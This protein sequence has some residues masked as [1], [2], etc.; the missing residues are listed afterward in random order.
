MYKILFAI[1]I[2][3]TSLNVF[4]QNK[5][6]EGL[7]EYLV[8]I[9]L[10]DNSKISGVLSTREGQSDP[11]V[12]VVLLPGHPS[13]VRPIMVE[14]GKVTKMNLSG[15]FLLRARRQLINNDIATL[16]VDCRDSSAIGDECPESYMA[17]KDRFDDLSLIVKE[18]RKKF[19]NI[20]KVW[21]LST[22]FGTV[23][24]SHIPKEKFNEY[25]GIIHTSTINN[26]QK[27]STQYGVKYDEIKVPQ[28]FVHHIND[29][30]TVSRYDGIAQ[31][32][33]KFKMPLYT[34]TG[35]KKRVDEKI[36]AD[37]CNAFS[38]HGFKGVEVQVMQLIR[39]AILEGI[40]SSASFE[41]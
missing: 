3:S 14:N 28:L 7:S 10:N 24:S 1:T 13:V 23:T 35:D 15:N 8:S 37:P 39:K 6:S 31:I 16:I 17:S 19:L 21:L 38:P 36:S 2:L 12:L 4:S 27:Y 22:S 30:C 32:S 5:S 40:G 18:A 9:Q 25:A 41:F 26:S 29:A 33:E 11:T 34:I 20:K